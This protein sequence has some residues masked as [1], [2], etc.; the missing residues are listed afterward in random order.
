MI[1]KN[2]IFEV[3]LITIVKKTYKIKN[4]RKALL[5]ILI[6]SFFT[7]SF[8]QNNEDTL[9]ELDKNYPVIISEI[10]MSDGTYRRPEKPNT[11]RFEKYIEG[12]QS[13]IKA[14][15]ED[16]KFAHNFILKLIDVTEESERLEHYTFN[17]DGGEMRKVKLTYYKQMMAADNKEFNLQVEMDGYWGKMKYNLFLNTKP[18]TAPSQTIT[19]N[20][21]ALSINQELTKIF[22]ALEEGFLQE[23]TNEIQQTEMSTFYTTKLSLG[24]Y[25]NQFVAKNKNGL[26]YYHASLPTDNQIHQNLVLEYIKHY[27]NETYKVVETPSTTSARHFTVSKQ[28]QIIGF[29]SLGENLLL[30]SNK[31][32]IIIS[33][34]ISSQRLKSSIESTFISLSQNPETLQGNLIAKEDRGVKFMGK[35][36]IYGSSISSVSFYE[37]ERMWTMESGFLN[38]SFEGMMYQLKQMKFNITGTKDLGMFNEEFQKVNDITQARFF[39]ITYTQSSGEMRSIIIQ[40]NKNR[41]VRMQLTFTSAVTKKN[42]YGQNDGETPEVRLI[43]ECFELVNEDTKH[44]ST[45]IKKFIAP[46]YLKRL[47]SR[48]SGKLFQLHEGRYYMIVKQN[49]SFVHVYTWPTKNKEYLREEIIFEVKKEGDQYYIFPTTPSYTINTGIFCYEEGKRNEELQKM[50]K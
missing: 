12:G 16:E 35:K 19:N 30:P 41:Q 13:Y 44:D 17:G 28:N 32:A 22:M 45:V 48:I 15:F 42:T 27:S 49:G 47:G 10:I 18:K 2:L 36:N 50:P 26:N 39:K 24:Q 25:G 1:E 3:V 43:R 29:I 21:K 38:S 33:Q 9:L 46:S 40:N 6:S 5:L 7:Y 4:M 23:M 14:I 20:T 34:S 37:K 31:P 8:A 11:I